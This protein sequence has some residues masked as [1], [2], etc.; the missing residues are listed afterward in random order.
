[1]KQNRYFLAVLAMVFILL[2]ACSPSAATSVSPGE[3]QPA[4]AATEAVS[5]D[6][7]AEPA[8]AAAPLPFEITIDATDYSFTAPEIVR[9][10][11]VLVNLTNSG[12]EPHHVQFLR[13]NDGVSLED[14]EAAL[15]QG[16]GP[17]LAMTQQVGGVG[18]IASGISAQAVLNLPAGEYA[19]LC[20]IPSPNDGTPHHAKGM[21]K[22]LT[23]QESSG[24]TAAE[25]EAD[26]AIRLKDF[27]FDM[28]ASLPAGP[29]T[30]QV[31]NDGPEPH[32]WNI[33]RLEEGKDLQDA[34][35]FLTAPD[36]PP[37]FVPVGGMNGLDVG[38]T[39]YV[40]FDFQPGNYLAICNIPSPKAEGHPHFTLGMVKEF[41]V[42]AS[43][44]SAFPTGK[45]VSVNDGAI[46]YEFN[47]DGAFGYYI[48]E[49]KVVDGTY[50]VDGDL[51]T[52]VDPTETDLQCQGSASYHWLFDGEKLT[53][54]PAGED[55]C[56]PRR[57]SFSD[58]YS[59]SD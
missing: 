40:E 12:Q 38:K 9:T 4:I 43:E 6:P 7:T 45:F 52:V 42:A 56:R 28:P 39:G 34:L 14:F 1:M 32:E 17:A 44:A 15:K 8:E 59:M 51:L 13:L 26:L 33:L 36:G 54:A 3:P 29:T 58:T 24:G 31:V 55:T 2:A 10:G 35:Q 27:T 48:G 5:P 30:I 37:P 25:P 21:V 16:D 53:F 47:Q 23:V 41:S 22:G 19:I 11:W 50:T 49:I 57:E 20:F 46:S 18:A